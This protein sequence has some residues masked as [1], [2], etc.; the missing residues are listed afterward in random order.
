MYSEW[1]RCYLENY[2]TEEEEVGKA[3]KLVHQEERE[4]C[5]DIVFGSTVAESRTDS[6]IKQYP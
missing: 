3:T 2:N 1:S 5:E 4:E 6:C